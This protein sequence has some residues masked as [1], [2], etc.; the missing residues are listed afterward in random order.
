MTPRP[1]NSTLRRIA[2]IAGSTW[3]GVGLIGAI[4]LYL[5]VVSVRTDDFR[6]LLGT[7]EA[8]LYSH[9]IL[10]T[11]AAL[12]LVSL[13]VATV[14][15]VPRR[16]SHAGAWCSHLGV[17]V[18]AAGSIWYGCA[19]VGGHAA[20]FWTPAGWTP[21]RDLY[22]KDS[23]AVSVRAKPTGEAVETVL[24]VD[25]AG[26]DRVQPM[27]VPLAGAGDGADLQVIEYAPRV[28]ITDEA[29]RNDS[30]V[31]APAVTLELGRGHS[32]GE[33][34]LSQGPRPKSF[35]RMGEYLLY[36]HA[37]PP[38]ADLARLRKLAA[39]AEAK[40]EAFTP[41]VI[42]GAAAP[43]KCTVLGPDGPTWEHAMP[44]G[45]LLS[46]P[47]A[48]RPLALRLMRTL[49]H[50]IRH[51]RI[52]RV[53]DETQ[54]VSGSIVRGALVS[55]PGARTV[56]LPFDECSVYL[57][58]T[59]VELGSGRKLLLKFSRVRVPLAGSAEMHTA[60]YLTYPGTRIPKDYRSEVTITSGG[61]A[62]S[63]VLCLNNP[64]M[65]GPLQLIQSNWQFLPGGR[66]TSHIFL[67][68][69]NRPGLW[70][71]WVGCI[72]IC[73]GFPYAFYVKPLLIARRRAPR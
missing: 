41:V 19:K 42:S 30:L 32:A 14:V 51:Y 40:G 25:P 44:V 52:E 9:P 8:G 37:D 65:V 67:E 62:R 16:W 60:E 4:F 27:R 64:V 61:S 23:F 1:P 58:P 49:S 3:I 36:Y 47:L 46:V 43:L 45:Q 17:A 28:R 35:L 6:R 54:G 56:W 18:L 55:V 53:T 5:G 21:I 33:I 48:R 57:D 68:V 31:E 38:P 15:R 71:I 66:E 10:L 29:W 34:T 12:M 20:T 59:V 39:A 7:T 50:A 73:V 24:P 22:L 72:L 2:R 13:T 69:R 70:L 26:V 11:L 63:E